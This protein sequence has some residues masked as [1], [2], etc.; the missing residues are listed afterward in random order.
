MGGRE[1]E[2]RERAKNDKGYM[3]SLTAEPISVYTHIYGHRRGLWDWQGDHQEGR[4]GSGEDNRIWMW[5]NY[6]G[7]YV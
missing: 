7:R 6:K 2:K 5:V 4:G 3:L 1:Q